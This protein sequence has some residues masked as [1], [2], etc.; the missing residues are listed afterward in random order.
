MK[1][2][3]RCLVKTPEENKLFGRPKGKCKNYITIGFK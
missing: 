1:N 3:Y 2:E